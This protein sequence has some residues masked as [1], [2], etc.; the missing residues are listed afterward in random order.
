MS[1]LKKI[2]LRSKRRKL[3]SRRRLNTDVLPRISV[4][5]SLNQIYAQLIDDQQQKTIVSCSTLELKDLSGDKK[6]KARSVGK[7][8]A[9]R[10]IEKGVTKVCFDRGGTLFHGRIKA[11]ADGAR[12]GGLEI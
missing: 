12:E 4:F 1:N 11:L 3:R 10:A 7:E 6:E 5:R 2:Q 9:R 8:I